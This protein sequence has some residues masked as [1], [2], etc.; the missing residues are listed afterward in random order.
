MR[1]L[2]GAAEDGEGSAAL[3]SMRRPDRLL[4][5]RAFNLLIVSA[6]AAVI[7]LVAARVVFPSSPKQVRPSLAS[8]GSE[9]ESLG[10][11]QP[12]PSI[13]APGYATDEAPSL[14][15]AVGL[16][17]LRGL[18]LDT[19]PGTQLELWVAWDDAYAE[20]PQVQKLA[21][22]VTLSRFIEPATPEGPVV[23]VLLVPEKAM[24]AVMYGDLYG[25]FSVARPS[26]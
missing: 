22:S 18:P 10:N 21:R 25:S 12:S 7:G 19:S 2:S 9:V 16:H 24:R 3:P 5:H 26:G 17:D 1:F 23:A 20:G 15:Y 8:L 6:V 11:V 4:S 14:E 13:S